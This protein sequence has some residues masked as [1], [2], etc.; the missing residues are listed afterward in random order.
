MTNFVLTQGKDQVWYGFFPHFLKT[1]VKHG[2]SARLGG[3]SKIPFATLNLG[4]HVGD[5]PDAVRENRRL[6][7]GATGVNYERIV[8]AKQV[9][10]CR[11]AVI[12][13]EHVGKGA[14]S[15]EEAMEDTDALITN[16]PNIPLLL[17]F[18]DCVPVLIV[19]PINKAIAAI[20]AGWKGSVANIVRETLKLM[21][22][23]YGTN[24]KLC[25]AGIGPSIGG[26]CY[27][28][29]HT[30]IE[31]LN[32]NLPNPEAY[33]QNRAGRSFLDLWELNR[34]QLIEAGLVDRNV[35]LSKVCTSC[36]PSLFF[37][38]RKENGK[39]G[40]IGAIIQIEE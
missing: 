18:A 16:V 31:S 39:T 21:E 40:R 15:Y 36:N 12:T 28:V 4:M 19:D 38:Y 27:E 6:F 37:S 13:E 29:N 26:C 23:K 20:H 32:R 5:D 34:N 8:T 7:C 25:L 3:C 11:V 1:G 14:F 22:S 30:V 33:I 9:H 2:I 17:F 35:I 10:G 24:P